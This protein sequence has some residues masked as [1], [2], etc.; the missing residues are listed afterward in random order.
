[1]TSA[2]ELAGLTPEGRTIVSRYDDIAHWGGVPALRFKDVEITNRNQLISALL[3]RADVDDLRIL[4]NA[5]RSEQD[6][7]AEER[8]RF[9]G[10]DPMAQLNR[11]RDEDARRLAEY[12]RSPEGRSVKTISLLERLAAGIETLVDRK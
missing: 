4:D 12:E 9:E 10:F 11:E 1:M 2:P 5:L 3:Q 7:V 6:R 8:R